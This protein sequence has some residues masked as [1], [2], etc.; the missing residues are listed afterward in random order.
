MRA[1]ASVFGGPNDGDPVCGVTI[2]R[3]IVTDFVEIRF[4][5][6]GGS[7]IDIYETYP[8]TAFWRC[9]SEAT[10]TTEARP[11]TTRRPNNPDITRPKPNPTTTQPRRTTT[12]QA[13][14]TNPPQS[15]VEADTTALYYELLAR[16]PARNSRVADTFISYFNDCVVGLG[17]L[18]PGYS[19]SALGTV[20]E[21]WFWGSRPAVAREWCRD[22]PTSEACL[23]A[24]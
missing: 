16:Y 6:T 22:V 5:D 8:L 15:Q 4:V 1:D 12:T 9:G 7:R 19:P 3:S 14:T 18:Y 17:S 21:G 2:C 23:Y 24:E 20:C 10:T 11:T 13:P